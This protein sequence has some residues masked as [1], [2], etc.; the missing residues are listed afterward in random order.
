M[1][2]D[3]VIAMLADVIPGLAPVPAAAANPPLTFA[4]IAGCRARVRVGAQW[5]SIESTLPGEQNM[6]ALQAMRMQSAL[7]AGIKLVRRRSGFGLR[8]EIPLLVETAAGRDWTC[9]Q[10]AIVYAGLR[11]AL[12]LKNGVP[13]SAG[14][15][16]LAF[17][18]A[19]VAEQCASGGWQASVRQ[20]AEVRVEF[21]SR[22][23]HRVINLTRHDNSIR[24]AVML[25][26]GAPSGQG[27]DTPLAVA[28]FLLRATRSMRWVRAFVTGAGDTLDAAGFECLLALPGGDQP[29]VMALDA[30]ATACEL[31]GC[32]AEML[33]ESPLLA[34][35]YAAL[36]NAPPS[37][38]AIPGNR[39]SP[40]SASAAGAVAEISVA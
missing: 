39:V 18:P 30:L 38:P 7:P 22:S 13:H 28:A 6:D 9:R 14:E 34:R 15:A 32:E 5:I 2:P 26:A 11:A 31:F 36:Y 29:V 1:K 35:H 33:A 40:D 20:D 4:R 10:A 12:G 27:P 25:E 8:A 19:V 37:S 21:D 23:A 16:G 17:D 24:A 3:A